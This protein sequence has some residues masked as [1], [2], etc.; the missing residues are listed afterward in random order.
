MIRILL[1]FITILGANFVTAQ[2]KITKLQYA[3]TEISV[4][5]RCVAKSEYELLDCNGFSAQWLFLDE[6]MVKQKIHEQLHSQ[7]EQQI[8]YKSKK[9]IDFYSQN[10]K[11]RG[12]KYEMKNG[13]YRIIGFGRVDN[14]PLLLNLGFGKDPK[15]NSVLT[16]FEKNFITF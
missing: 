11:F 8:E 16:E 12:A 14:L 1:T 15:N 7:I 4:P 13:T 10:Q 5:E 3:K 6:E 2:K 9:N